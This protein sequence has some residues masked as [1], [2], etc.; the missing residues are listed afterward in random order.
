MR[1][2]GDSGEQTK[3]SWGYRQP[4]HRRNPCLYE[5]SKRRSGCRPGE[6]RPLC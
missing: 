3:R 2:C 4:S 1:W 6:L 5:G